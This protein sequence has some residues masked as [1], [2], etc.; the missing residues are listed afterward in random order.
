MN[1][2]EVLAPLRA[3]IRDQFTAGTADPRIIADTLLPTLD[4]PSRDALLRWALVEMT[5]HV[6]AGVRAAALNRSPA[7]G[8]SYVDELRG[9]RLL[10][11]PVFNG[12]TWLLMGDCTAA[13]LLAAASHNRELAAQNLERAAQL[14]QIAGLL[15]DGQKVRDLPPDLWD[16]A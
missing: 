8:R 1:D 16:A 3:L 5:R 4:T 7:P 12:S 11:V 9:N 14:E 15:D 13:D 2:Y 6:G 10:D